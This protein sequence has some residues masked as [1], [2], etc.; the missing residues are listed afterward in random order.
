MSAAGRAGPGAALGRAGLT[1]LV[2]VGVDQLTKTIVR[3]S[4]DPTETVS[5]LPGLDFVRV[6][7]DGVAFG[8]FDNLS[9]AVLVLIGVL[10]VA[11]LG[12]FM[13]REVKTRPG[14]WFPVGLLAGGAVGNLIDRLREGYV[15][16]FIDLPAWPAFNVADAEITVGVILLAWMLLREPQE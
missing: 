3:G 5:V 15:T 16:D 11:G 4:I 1:M 6:A 14:I 13:M 9:S 2:A 10:F 7:N 12:A 8:L